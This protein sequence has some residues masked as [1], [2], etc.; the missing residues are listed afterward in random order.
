MANGKIN[1]WTILVVLLLLYAFVPAFSGMVNGIFGG[2]G[3]GITPTTTAPG[4]TIPCPIEDVTVTISSNNAYSKGTDITDGDHRVFVNGIDKGYTS[5]DGSVT[6]SPDDE[7]TVIFGENSTTYYSEVKTKTAP[8]SGTLEMHGDLAAYDITPTFTIW[9]EEGQV[10]TTSANAQDMGSDTIYN[11]PIRIKT[12]SKYSIGNPTNPGKGNVLCFH[13]NSTNFDSVKLDGADS[14]AIPKNLTGI[15]KKTAS[16]FSIPV[17]PNDPNVGTD[18][19]WEGMIISDTAGT[20]PDQ[21]SNVSILLFD[22]A[23][24]L[25]GDTL[26]IIYGVEDEDKNDLGAGY[27]DIAGGL[28]GVDVFHVS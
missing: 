1:G 2:L 14:V 18:G 11:N 6:V 16:C 7:I 27:A 13:Y 3:G 19:T 22:T 23:V 5:E 12:T 17:I 8:C 28:V 9:T 26:E 10:A 25:D 15:A 24:D 4:V 21:S 20:E